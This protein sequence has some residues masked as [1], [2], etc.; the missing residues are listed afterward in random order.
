MDVAKELNI[1]LKISNYKKDPPTLTLTPWN[2]T[3]NPTFGS[4]VH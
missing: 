3:G 1:S 4:V 2:M